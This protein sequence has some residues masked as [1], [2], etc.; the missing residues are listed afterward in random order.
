M[1]NFILIFVLSAIIVL[2]S[3]TGLE[4]KQYKL[5]TVVIDAGH[6]G[7][8]PGCHGKQSQEAAVT[9]K[10]ALELGRI[11][12]ENYPDVRVIYTRETD[13]FV[14][15]H[16]RAGIANKNNANL[17]ISIHCNSGPVSVHG[18][19]TFTMGLHTSEG[20]LEV[21]K[22]ENAVILTEKDYKKNYDGFDPSSPM[23]HILIANY[24]NAYIE[25]SLRFAQKVES[26][27]KKRV[28]RT[29]RG[30]K[31]AGLVVLWKSAMPS[32]L[33]EIGFLTNSA[34]E[35]YL[36]QKSNQTYIASGIFRAF[37]EYKLELESMN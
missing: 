20:N 29:S 24:Q 10:V 14:E 12:K 3:F 34:E 32:A 7:K 17:F 30:V 31:Q 6:G 21:A 4:L 37:K 26:Q 16:D 11:I 1:K 33:I 25:N 15:L 13:K 22:R 19:E 35:K 9:L 27:F 5:K 8:D 23:A 18:T 28:G 2:S 36:T